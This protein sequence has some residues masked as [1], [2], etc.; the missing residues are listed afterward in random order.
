MCEENEENMENTNSEDERINLPEKRK[1]RKPVWMRDYETG[2]GLFEEENEE[3]EQLT[4][5]IQQLAMF[6][7]ND[8]TTFEEAAKS[9]KWLP[10]CDSCRNDTL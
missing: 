2:V 7:S 5:E 8:P 3:L 4:Q 1:R 6:V 10:P 9:Q